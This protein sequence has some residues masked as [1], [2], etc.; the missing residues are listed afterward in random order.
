MEKPNVLVMAS[1][2]QK[3]AYYPAEEINISIHRQITG[4]HRQVWPQER[5][6]LAGAITYCVSGNGLGSLCVCILAH[7]HTRM[8]THYTEVTSVAKGHSGQGE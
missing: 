7:T 3:L 1:L 2:A 8:Y 6:L 4:Q 5:W